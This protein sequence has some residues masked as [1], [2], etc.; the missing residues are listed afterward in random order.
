MFNFFKI[1]KKSPE[2]KTEN[3]VK[4]ILAKKYS[5]FQKLLSTNNQVLE[6]MADMEEKFSGEYL[7]DVH[8]IKTNVRLIGHEVLKII[9]NLNALSNNRYPHLYKIHQ[10]ISEEIDK[11]LV[12]KMEI[13]V[14]DL[15]VP[16]EN[17]TGESTV[18]AGGKIAKLGEVK[19]I[20]NL[21]TPDGFSISSYAFIKFMDHNKLTEK[22]INKLSTLSIDNLEELNRFSKAVSH[23]ITTSAVPPDLQESIDKAYAE[24]CKKT[25]K[26][27]MVAVRSSAIR[28]DSEFSF[29]GQYATFLNVPGDSIVQ[30]Y[31][32]VVASLFT[33]RAIFYSKTKGFSEEEMVMAVGVI[34]M[35]DASAGGVM[36]TRNPNDRKVD[37]ILINAIHGLG[38]PVVDGTVTPDS[39]T[40]SRYPDGTIIEKKISAQEK[41]LVCGKAAEIIEVMVPEE[42]GGDSVS[43]MNRLK[44]LLAMRLC[45]N[46]ITARLRTLNGRSAAIKRFI[47]CNQGL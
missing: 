42:K 3:N 44:N 4:E 39:Y 27:T 2:M 10:N 20:L 9:E 32:E 31:K 37:H 26:E 12:Y 7:F 34:G 28:E 35:V 6:L 46:S 38:K 29:A 36:Y 41:M 45:W 33:P 19:S 16:L 8:Y 40:V 5:Y 21:L 1:F 25:G 43:Q 17:L 11:I 18:I 13:P 47:S 14:S 22:I 30:K 15:T 24:L 23:M